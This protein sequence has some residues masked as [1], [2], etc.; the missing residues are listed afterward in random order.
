MPYVDAETRAKLQSGMPPT[1]P[2]ELN[3]KLTMAIL[4]QPWTRQQVL[5]DWMLELGK[6]YIRENGL[7]Y[8]RINDVL[9]AYAGA[10]LELLRRT[11]NYGIEA[12]LLREVAERFYSDVAAPY[13]DTKIAANGDLPYLQG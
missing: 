13:E 1:G 7:S 4:A 10:A 12:R 6:Q 9:G 2:G 8:Q 11:R 5:F 3:Y